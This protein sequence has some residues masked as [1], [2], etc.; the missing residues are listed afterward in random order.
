MRTYPRIE[1]ISVAAILILATLACQIDVGGP[2][3]PWPPIPSSDNAAD[4]LAQNWENALAF[5][6]D[7]GEV[8][9]I[10]NE[11]QLTA[12][13][14]QRL[15]DKDH[16]LLEQPQ[17]YLRDGKIQI[18]GTSQRDLI[19]ADILLSI[20]PCLDEEGNLSLDVSDATWGPLP[21][22]KALKDS[23]SAIVTEA[24]TGSFGSLATGIRIT[25]IAIADG[26]LALVGTL[27]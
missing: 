22:P 15:K 17:V 13:L 7:R 20:T 8:T 1:I 27:R 21:A 5:S 11:S 19:K 26:E 14:T 4:S 6:G 9:I 2:E 3:N 16:P 18:Y 23:I 10:I 25:T 24:F 12:F